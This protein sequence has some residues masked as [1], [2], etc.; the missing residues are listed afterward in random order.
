MWV[1][2]EQ[3]KNTNALWN[4]IFIYHSDF[5]KYIKVE[6]ANLENIFNYLF[7]IG[8]KKFL[9]KRKEIST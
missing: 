2:I 1:F 6:G 7:D 8:V 4:H 9:S 3:E 5:N